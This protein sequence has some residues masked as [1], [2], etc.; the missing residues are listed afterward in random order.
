M[1]IYL[2]HITFTYIKARLQSSYRYLRY[3]SLAHGTICPCKQWNSVSSIHWWGYDSFHSPFRGGNG[4]KDLWST[5]FSIHILIFRTGWLEW[6]K[7]KLNVFLQGIISLVCLGHVRPGQLLEEIHPLHIHSLNT[8]FTLLLTTS[9]CWI[10]GGMCLST[11]KII[12]I[13]SFWWPTLPHS[14]EIAARSIPDEVVR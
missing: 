6:R 3:K 7:S 5:C 1:Q 12:R 4:H 8:W 14:S 2:V 11:L 13:Q 9:R 10:D